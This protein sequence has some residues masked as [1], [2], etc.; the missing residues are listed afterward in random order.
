[1]EEKKIYELTP[2]QD[3]V[4]LQCRLSIHKNVANISSSLTI[5][6]E[7][8]FELLKKAF[9]IVAERN[10]CLR[11]KFFK[12][13]KKLMQTFEEKKEY[14]NIPVYEFN[15]KETQDKYINEFIKAPIKFLKGVVAEPVF[16]KT[17]DNKSM[18]LMKVCH[19]ILDIYGINIIYKELFDVYKALKNNTE[20]PE[21]PV[22]FEEL[23]VADLKKKN[24]ESF[25]Q[26]N[27]EY[28]TEYFSSKEN[29]YYAGVHG[30]ENKIWQKQKKK[31]RHAMKLFLFNNQTKG[32]QKYIDKDLTTKIM[33]YCKNTNQSPANFLFYALSITASK[34]NGKVKNM[35]P[36]ELCNCR[37]TVQSKKCAGT[38]AQSILCYTTINYEK[39]FKENFDDFIKNQNSLYRHIGYPDLEVQELLHKYYKSSYLEVYYGIAFSFLPIVMPKGS[40]FKIYS[41]GYGA[42]PCYIAQLYR[43]EDGDIVM[44]YDSQKKIIGQEEIDRF[45]KKYIEVLEQILEDQNI[46]LDN[47]K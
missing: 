13:G 33:E 7:I 5:E 11:L 1:M 4:Y 2:A 17:F 41:N 45:H 38:K 22:Q 3:V 16:I 30:E 42:L 27:K 21:V 37:G 28:F 12:S 44:A 40:Q 25:N 36:M 23:I 18:V 31:G 35:L 46:V 24:D 15:T 47:L 19:L 8:D 10:D 43:V 14:N 29:P 6:E 39:S 9:N 26:K 32:F 34:L 20:M